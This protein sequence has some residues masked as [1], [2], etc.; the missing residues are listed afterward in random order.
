MQNYF[1]IKSVLF[2]IVLLIDAMIT[3][4]LYDY[5]Y[6]GIERAFFNSE[7]DHLYFQHKVKNIAY[8]C[9][10]IFLIILIFTFFILSQI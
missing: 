8:L 4:R 9:T 7:I 1:W 2:T 6:K 3:Q 5:L 10:S